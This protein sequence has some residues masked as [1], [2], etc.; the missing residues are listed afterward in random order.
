MTL[1]AASE[2]IAAKRLSPV[3][4]TES[5]LEQVERHED[6]VGAFAALTA[7]TA[8]EQAALA[9]EELAAGS[10][11]GALHGIPL[12][13]KALV[14]RAG[15]ETTSSSRTRR[16]HIPRA[17][18]AVVERLDRAG[19]VFIGQTHSHEF[20]YGVVTPTTRNP[21]NTDH[22][23]GGSSGGSGAALAARMV[24]GAIGTDTAGSIRIP[25]AVCGV[26][27][28][29]PTYGRVSRFGTTTLSWSLDHIGPMG[30]TA[31]DTALLLQTLAGYDP[32]DPASVDVVVP[33][34]GASLDAGVRELTIAIPSNYFFDRIDAEVEAAFRAAAE[35]LEAQGARLKE[36]RLPM[37]DQCMPI[38]YALLVAEASAY[39]Q[40]NLRKQ[41]DLY[42]E[43]VRVM[44]EAGEML[45]ATDYI[46][47]VRGRLLLQQAWREAFD[48]IDA[49]LAPT[50][51]APAARVGEDAIA[52]PDGVIEPL[53]N[54]YVRTC[55]PANLTGLPAMSVPCGITTSGLPIGMQIIG[56]PFDESTVLQIGCAYQAETEWT[57]LVPGLDGEAWFYA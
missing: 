14:D 41:S 35:T 11:R 6:A 19:A 4:L 24:L 13:V 15:V 54:A 30:R 22:I 27:G 38:E 10:R 1:T 28:L 20:A 44:L 21:W 48:E 25:S 42:E 45:L 26:T 23:P 33:D 12:G 17:D 52:W 55:A 9:T 39:H 49:V 7:E 57:G 56:R 47:A 37:T 5:V 43:D 16:G 46:R 2:E 36:V 53:V 40:S 31:A 3:E 50:L 51:P 29:K 34:Y 18:A 32:R 8:L